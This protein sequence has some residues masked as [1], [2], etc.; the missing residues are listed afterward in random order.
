MGV[1]SGIGRMFG[2][3]KQAAKPAQTNPLM[4]WNGAAPAEADEPDA[5]D[6][7]ELET[8]ES[9]LRG[10]R[11]LEAKPDRALAAQSPKNR[12]ELLTELQKNYAEVLNLV[13]KVDAHLDRQD[14]RSER[15]LELAQEATG[16]LERLDHLAK[17]DRLE[18][19]DQLDEIR[20]ESSAAAEA[21]RELGALARDG[22]T[23]TEGRL[24]EQNAVLSSMRDLMHNAERHDEEIATS[25]DAF[26]N[27]MGGMADATGRLGEALAQ[28]RQTDL[29]REEQIARMITRS[30]RGMMV[31]MAMVVLIA[32][33]ALAV[34]LLNA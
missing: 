11:V 4:T 9:G 7:F 23:R 10:D 20:S 25:L 6:G 29:Q 14:Q 12:Q 2:G 19:L 21:I 15:L 8:D 34:V 31:A 5:L 1:F 32:V 18:K 28:M 26:R 33:V 24:E 16:R 17:L 13:R 22:Q 30:Q 3:R 27:S